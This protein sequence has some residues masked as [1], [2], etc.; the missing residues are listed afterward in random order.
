[1][2]TDLIAS[3]DELSQLLRR[4]AARDR[5]RSEATVQADVRQLLLTGGLGLDDHDLDVQLETQV[6]DRRCIDVEIGFTVIEVKK[7]LSNQ[8]VVRAAEEQLAGYVAARAAQTGQRYVG[9]LTDGRE[10]HAYQEQGAKLVEVTQHM[11]SP[12]KPDGTALLFWLE[13]VLA[14]RKGV[15]PTPNERYLTDGGS[16]AFVMPNAVLDRGYYAVSERETTPDSKD[17]VAITFTDSWDL[18]RLRPHFFPR[19][20]AVVFG[21]RSTTQFGSPL[22]ARTTR[23]TGRLPRGSDTWDIVSTH[24]TR[25]DLT[26][27][28]TRKV[29]LSPPTNLGSARAPLS[30]P[31]SCS[32][33]KGSSPVRSGSPQAGNSFAPH[34]AVPKRCR[35]RNCAHSKA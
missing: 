25:Y 12:T 24:V 15:T 2:A 35:G 1:M 20:A 34:A 14:T 33:S 13:G 7:D 27:P 19:G 26:S 29:P 28:S 5:V 18:R 30:C 9:V 23:W 17:P 31:A 10:W 11:L 6:G 3:T 16:F 21:Q 22:P 32:W 4:L 8:G